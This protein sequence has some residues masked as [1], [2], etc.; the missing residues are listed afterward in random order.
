MRRRTPKALAA[1]GYISPAS[2]DAAAALRLQLEERLPGAE[3]LGAF[4]VNGRS[5]IA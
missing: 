5:S 3:F 4:R 1:K 2:A